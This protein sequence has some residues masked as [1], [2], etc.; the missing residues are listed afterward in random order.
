MPLITSVE[1][2]LR[3]SARA[4]QSTFRAG[5]A[6]NNSIMHELHNSKVSPAAA[7]RGWS[8]GCCHTAGKLSRA[9]SDWCHAVGGD[10][11]PCRLRL[12]ARGERKRLDTPN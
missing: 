8:A 10:K 9:V 7:R 3:L 6:H 5:R 11:L 4:S 2:T 1:Y 12:C